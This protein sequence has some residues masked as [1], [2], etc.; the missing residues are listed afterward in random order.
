[1]ANK[2]QIS[3]VTWILIGS[4]VIF[5]LIF[6]WFVTTFTKVPYEREL[7]YSSEAR[8]N[9]FLAAEKFLNK[10]SVGLETR[11]DFSVFEEVPGQY[12][13]ILINGSRIGMSSA[14]REAMLDWVQ[15]GGHLVLLATEFYEYDF[16]SSRDKFLDDRGVR[17]YSTEDDYTDYSE[18]ESTT[19]LNFEGFEKD[20]E[21]HFY[22]NGYIEDTSGEASFISGPD[23]ADQFIQ[24]QMGEGLLTVIVD[25]SIWQNDRIDEHDHAMFLTQLIGNSAKAWLVYNRVQPSLY[26]LMIQHI[27]LVVVSFVFIL[28]ALLIGQ[29]WRKGPARRDT[30]PV[31]REIMQHIAAAG[32]FAYRRDQGYDLSQ[33]MHNSISHRMSQLVHGYMRLDGAKQLEKLATITGLPKNELQLLWHHDVENK[34]TFLTKVQLVQEIRKHL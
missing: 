10:L 23:H 16:N 26:T 31:Q 18:E 14:R 29:L 27:P 19:S 15:Q 30:P 8:S 3:N 5:T 28:L 24:Y 4:A 33:Q 2:F 9:Q 22:A 34:E 12:D 17:Y 25:F 21:V 1:M 6:Y 32:E 20:T 11:H 7:G 13:T